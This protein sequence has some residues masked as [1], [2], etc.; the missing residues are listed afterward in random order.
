MSVNLAAMV[1]PRLSRIRVEVPPGKPLIFNSRGALSFR[2][3][4]GVSV[5]VSAA[6]LN[7]APASGMTL[8]CFFPLGTVVSRKSETGRPEPPRAFLGTRR[9]FDWLPSWA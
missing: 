3:P 7:D 4:R 9:R 5:T 8:A 1:E 6:P 2:L